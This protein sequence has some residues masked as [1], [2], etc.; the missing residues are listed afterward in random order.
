MHGGWV[1]W[2]LS[3]PEPPTG[4]I[5]DLVHS[6]L[7]ET[8]TPLSPL[9]PPRSPGAREAVRWHARVSQSPPRA[10]ELMLVLVMPAA[11]CSRGRL[12]L[13]LPLSLASASGSGCLGLSLSWL[14]CPPAALEEAA[15]V[16]PSYSRDS[17][18]HSSGVLSF[19]FF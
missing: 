18:S 13:L 19:F 15:E 16:C 7:P 14:P 1:S 3:A 2:R 8:H 6:L 4:V 17:D 9:A 5:C 11:L 12:A 10:A